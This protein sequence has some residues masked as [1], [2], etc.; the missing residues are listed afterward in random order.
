[1]G[2]GV[3][4]EC[5]GESQ[6]RV[7]WGGRNAWRK[8]DRGGGMRDERGGDE[9]VRLAKWT[10][11][12]KGGGR[13][14]MLLGKKKTSDSLRSERESESGQEGLKKRKINAFSS[15]K[16]SFFFLQVQCIPSLMRFLRS[17][18]TYV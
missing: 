5:G 15:M 18:Y 4:G 11:I 7:L 16:D 8:E 2:E 12:K 3:R 17:G 13:E 1:V 14:K 10:V 6:A 9:P